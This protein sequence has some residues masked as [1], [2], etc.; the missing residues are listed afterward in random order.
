MKKPAD[1]DVVLIRQAKNPAHAGLWIDA[2]GGGILHCV[3]GIGVVF[4][5]PQSLNACGWYLDSFYRVKK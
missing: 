4:Q 5:T 3:R 2:D 1:G